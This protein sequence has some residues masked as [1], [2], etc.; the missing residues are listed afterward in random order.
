MNSLWKETI[1]Q[2]QYK[3]LIEERDEFNKNNRWKKRGVSILPAKFGIAFTATFLNQGSA[4]VSLLTDGTVLINHGGIE[5]GQ[6]LNTKVIQV[7][8]YELGIPVENIYIQ[9][10]STEKV[11]NPI[12]TAASMGSDVYCMAV[13]DACNQL[14]KRLAPLRK[15]KPKAQFKDLVHEAFHDRINLQAQGWAK[16]PNIH[17]YDFKKGSTPKTPPFRY[18]TAG[19]AV[20]TVEIDTLTGDHKILRTDIVMDL[21]KSI[22][23]MIDIGQIE[24]AFV[25][26]A[27]W[28]TI[29]EVVWGDNNHL[30]LKPGH[31]FISGPG[32]Y[33]I[34]S[35]DDIP[36]EFNVTLS[37]ITKKT[38]AIHSSK[39]VGEPPLLLSSS[40]VMAI[41]DAIYEA[42][43]NEGFTEWIEIDSPLTVERIRMSCPD[44]ITKIVVGEN[45][46]TFKTKGSW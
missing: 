5:M 3:K 21:G 24:G 36:S 6:G 17:L 9:D 45:Y 39:G 37:S 11:A 25:Q 15:K 26:G 42:R 27:G 33:K 14:N 31:F 4:I 16:I 7:A 20:S 23:P 38:P 32:N 44:F 8:A 19:C 30:W 1:K 28:L 43:K 13:Q 34:P 35:V 10:T 22:N 46:N 29:E 2:G 40:V 12:Q 41:R 18:F